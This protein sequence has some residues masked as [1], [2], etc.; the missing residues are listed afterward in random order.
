[1]FGHQGFSES[2]TGVS[3]GLAF[4]I[5]LNVK[6]K[7]RIAAKLSTS[8][9]KSMTIDRDREYTDGEGQTQAPETI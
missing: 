3:N 5:A 4:M 8:I 1:M 7:T 6:Q 9:A 2:K